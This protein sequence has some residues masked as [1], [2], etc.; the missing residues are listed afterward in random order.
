MGIAVNIC[1]ANKHLPG[2]ETYIRTVKE[3]VIIIAA[4]LPFKRYPPWLIIKMVYNC[5][6][7]LNSFPHKNSLHV[8]I[9]PRA[10]KTGRKLTYNTH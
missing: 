9:S 6:F 8:T 5:V 7:W 1:A 10:K 4:T 3:R 2:I